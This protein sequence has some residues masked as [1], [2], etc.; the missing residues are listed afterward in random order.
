MVTTAPSSPIVESA[1][2]PDT[3]KERLGIGLGL[4]AE[5]KRTLGEAAKIMGVSVTTVR[6]LVTKGELPA[7]R[8]GSKRLVL[9]R[10]IET[11]LSARY[12]VQQPTPTVIH[13]RLNPLPQAVLESTHLRR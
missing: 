8:I 12:G 13:N 9:L 4:V 7:L 5:P 10:D 3:G 2:L 11:F 6:T 1:H